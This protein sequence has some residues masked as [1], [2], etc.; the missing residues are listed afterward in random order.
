MHVERLVLDEPVAAGD[1]RAVRAALEQEAA[2][3]L[4]GHAGLAAPRPGA[5]DRAPA[6]TV[7]LAASPRATGGVVGRSVAAAVGKAI[8]GRP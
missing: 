8:G 4:A 2:L 6:P 5:Y 7:T 1:A 3:A